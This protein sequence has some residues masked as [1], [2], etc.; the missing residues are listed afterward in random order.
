MAPA[1][2]VID[3]GAPLA[4]AHQLMREHQI[5]HLPVMDGSELVGL[6]SVRDLHVM[7]SL[8][9]VDPASVSVAEA[10]STELYIVDPDTELRAVALNMYSRKLGSALVV[11]D[12]KLVGLFTTVDAL[13]VLANVQ[14]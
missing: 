7:E 11:D 5:R 14:A 9:D 3:K 1:P 4:D 8:K 13:R 12:G 10:M 6:V 2:I